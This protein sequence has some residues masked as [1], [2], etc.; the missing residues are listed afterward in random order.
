MAR[1]DE[2]Q[3]E[4]S[5]LIVPKEKNKKTKTGIRSDWDFFFHYP[6]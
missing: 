1:H 4:R 5:E 6:N 3:S 2:N